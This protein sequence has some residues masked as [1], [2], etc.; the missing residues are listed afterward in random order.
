[1]LKLVVPVRIYLKFVSDTQETREL[2]DNNYT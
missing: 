1:M 2:K